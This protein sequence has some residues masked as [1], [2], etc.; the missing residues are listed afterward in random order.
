MAIL[1]LTPD[2]FSNDGLVASDPSTVLPSLDHCLES[3]V[4][5][6]DVG[7]QST[8]PGASPISASEEIARVLPTFQYI[9][10]L[11]Q[12]NTLA[13]SID[14]FHSIVARAAISAGA[15]II[16]DVSGGMLDP[17]MLPTAAELNCTIILMHIRGTPQTM[18]TLTDYPQGII[19]GVGSELL[20]R[21][22]AAEEAGIPRW[23]IILDPGL[24]FAKTAAQSLELLRSMDQLRNFP[25]LEELPWVVGPSRKGFIGKITG[26][27]EPKSRIIGTAIAVGACVQQGVEIVRVHDVKA[28]AEAAKMADALWKKN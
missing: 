4:S 9:R 25:G 24:G 19:Q 6:L 23:R 27:V 20:I 14:T 2:S 26:V 11:P 10:S 8:R 17:E 15:D 16:N 13:L 28:M 7:G 1:N 12:Y 22:R 21:V 18:N 3:N 5:I